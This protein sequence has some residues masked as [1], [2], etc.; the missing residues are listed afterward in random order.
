MVLTP[1]RE[2]VR[3]VLCDTVGLLC[4]NGLGFET[5]LSVDALIGIT[6]D[7]REV[8]LVTIKETYGSERSNISGGVSDNIGGCVVNVSFRPE[9]KL[10]D[11]VV[12]KNDCDRPRNETVAAT[13][14]SPHLPSSDYFDGR[15]A[16]DDC[17]ARAGSSK[18]VGDS[19]VPMMSSSDVKRLVRRNGGVDVSSGP[20][21]NKVKRRR[22][23]NEIGERIL[24]PSDMKT[25]PCLDE[26]TPDVSSFPESS[27]VND[28]RSE[29]KMPS[30]VT[31]TGV[32]SRC[33]RK[34]KSSSPVCYSSIDDLVN[35]S[36]LAEAKDTT[37]TGHKTMDEEEAN[38]ADIHDSSRTTT[39]ATT[40]FDTR[41]EETSDNDSDIVCVKEEFSSVPSGSR[42]SPCSVIDLRPATS[43]IDRKVLFRGEGG[44]DAQLTTFPF[45]NLR[46]EMVPYDDPDSSFSWR[47]PSAQ[48]RPHKERSSSTW[49]YQDN[50]LP[51]T[52]AYKD[53]TPPSDRMPVQ[54]V[55]QSILL[56]DGR[57]VPLRDIQRLRLCGMTSGNI[58]TMMEWLSAHDGKLGSFQVLHGGVNLF[59]KCPPRLIDRRLLE[60]F[61]IP[62]DVYRWS[63]ETSRPVNI[64]TKHSEQY[65]QKVVSSSPYDDGGATNNG[66]C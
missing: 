47:D 12:R 11:Y 31:D 51:S 62:W 16:N 54:S 48:T 30:R 4:K 42:V 27:V 21:K 57:Y 53:L 10:N 13:T 46:F 43:S 17:A 56:Y 44:H 32:V 1:D 58:R 26:F 39:H 6:I 66:S 14:C 28:E 20:S 45:E 52:S 35:D 36:S 60:S 63:Y 9:N 7:R 40:R 50:A 65:W 37:S 64:T 41:R 5:E 22:I 61:G 23:C 18:S 3:Q 15:D 24:A 59:Y 25:E 8:F 19:D 29:R 55:L 49:L 33:R 2:R 34:S 38:D